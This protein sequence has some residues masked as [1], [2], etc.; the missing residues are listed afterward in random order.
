MLSTH[1]IDA[2]RATVILAAGGAGAAYDVRLRIVPNWLCGGSFLAALLLAAFLSLPGLE[3]ALLGGAL[4]GG[5]LV[6]FWLFGWCGAGDA[7]IGFAFGA[8]LGFPLAMTGLL[9]GTLAGGAWCALLIV[10]SL[11]RGA[12]GIWRGACG[13]GLLGAWAAAKVNDVW[14]YGMPYALF[15]GIGCA[16]ALVLPTVSGGGV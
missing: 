14:T 2:L 3:G 4:F 9:F 7:K 8:L 6:L 5:P 13:G 12:A 10:Y 11:S 1:L 16:A 15:L